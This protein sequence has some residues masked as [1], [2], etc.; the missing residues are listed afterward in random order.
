MSQKL[1]GW[2]GQDLHLQPFPYE[3]TA[4]TLCATEP[5][6]GFAPKTTG[7]KP[8]MIL[9]HH[10]PM[11]HLPGMAPGSSGNRPDVLLLN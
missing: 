3:R 6:I 4:L 9:F 2:L 7:C 1:M 11:V 8:E 5:Q 10:L